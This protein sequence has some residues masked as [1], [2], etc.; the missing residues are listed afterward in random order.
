[1]R[2]KNFWLGFPLLVV[3]ASCSASEEAPK[4]LGHGSVKSKDA[5]LCPLPRATF[6]GDGSIV[7]LPAPTGSHAI[8]TQ[9]RQFVDDARP[10][11][12]TPDP[13][14]YR[15][16]AVQLWYPADP[17][18]DGPTA[19]YAHTN[20]GNLLGLV[21]SLPK[22]WQDRVVV[23][24]RDSVALPA[25]SDRFPVLLFSH[26]LGMFRQ[27]YTTL[28]EELVSHGFVVAAISHT[29]DAGGV[30][31]PDGTWTVLNTTYT[32]G[33]AGD[34]SVTDLES[35]FAKLDAHV[36]V[37]ADDDRFVL[38]RLTALDADDDQGL[39]T[40]RL[41]LSHVGILGHSYGGAG[42]AEA[43]ANDTRFK[44]GLDYDGTL[45][46]PV[47]TTGGRSLETPFMLQTAGDNPEQS[48]C[49]TCPGM[50]SIADLYAH[51]QGPGY[52]IT[53][54]H[55]LHYNF[56]DIGILDDAFGTARNANL[57]T[58]APERALQIARAYTLAFFEKHLLGKAE[59]LLDGPSTDFADVTFAKK[60]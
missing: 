60:L 7:E 21:E 51:L 22:G 24:A 58:V 54:A 28:I 31:F 23:H 48:W 27:T 1:M 36:H 8:G 52:E 41:D 4:A 11:E 42:A 45:F 2:S 10:E 19:A 47:R 13:G 9:L 33:P 50:N 20:E 32:I 29:G 55:G 12:L 3:M 6:D 26:G 40:G 16:L 30:D 34:A 14:D 44:A 57:G 18:A 5:A 53:I 49:P 43:C 39:L 59:P 35:Y 38:D 46:S 56:T 37:W 15:K 25:G 17:C